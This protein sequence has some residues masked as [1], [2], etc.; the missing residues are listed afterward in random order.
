VR[1]P[2]TGLSRATARWSW[3]GCVAP[4]AY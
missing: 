1:A 2:A 3:S 4:C